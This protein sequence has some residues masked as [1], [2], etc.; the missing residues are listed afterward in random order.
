MRCSVYGC[1]S[2]NQAKNFDN[3]ISF[4]SFPKTKHVLEQWIRLCRVSDKFNG[5]YARI[6][7]KHFNASDF[8]RNLK[9]ELL[10]PSSS[11]ARSARK[12][13][14]PE[15]VP[16]KHLPDIEKQNEDNKLER[17]ANHDKIIEDI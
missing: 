7:S 10:G 5:K 6:C 15:A 12:M 9:L 2:D 4:Y 11:S 16:S 13:L 3:N 14:K 17:L 8:K 1:N